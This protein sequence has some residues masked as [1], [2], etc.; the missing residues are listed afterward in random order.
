MRVI[1][2]DWSGDAVYAARKIWLAEA[3][4]GRLLRLEDG[5][6][7]SELA[8]HLVELARDEPEMVVGLDFAFSAP[9]WFLDEHGL[10]SAPDL[11]RLAEHEG[12][13][14]L[15][16]CAPPF[17]GRK[18]TRALEAS[19]Q[20]RRTEAQLASAGARP[21][22]IFQ[23]AGSGA[24]GTGSIR[25]MAVLSR[26]SREGFSVWP[27]AP[28]GWPRI[29]EIYPRLLTGAIKKRRREE[30]E[31]YLRSNYPDLGDEWRELAATSEDSFDA[32]IS[33][34]AMS[35]RADELAS[36]DW[37]GD[38]QL[39]REGAIWG[40][41]ATPPPT[42]AKPPS[43]KRIAEESTPV[44]GSVSVRYTARIGDIPEPERPR[45]RLRRYGP[46]ALS[47]GELL[48]IVLG[49]GGRGLSALDLGNQV[50]ARL[51]GLG[52]IQKATFDELQDVFAVGPAKAAQIKAA[53][54]LGKRLVVERPAESKLKM[55]SPLDVA[56][57][58]M[59]DMGTLEQEELRVL[60]VNARNELDD[61]RMVYRGNVTS[62][63]VRPAEVLR[64]AVRTNM[65]A[66]VLVHNH[67]S[68][69]PS[70]SSADIEVTK[71]ILE[72]GRILGISV[73]DHIVIGG[74]RFVSMQEQKLG[75][76]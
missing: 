44:P 58:L 75:F 26:L 68:G 57:L 48:A 6:S 7:P 16:E 22:S 59:G 65:P 21:K 36:L 71:E 9:A 39:R 46:G 27:F 47:S 42:A 30:R 52:G 10:A 54:E 67:P 53:L 1:A 56:M 66:V 20:F 73:L 13:R 74:G 63:Q 69:D 28:P 5:R 64:D 29:I 31:E 33:A 72:A 18:G 35:C 24:V 70:P 37:S 8:Q 17:W 38:E 55:H 2:V 12:E 41:S 60:L 61:S 25:G 23:I 45:E 50:L 14:W 49:S 40:Y 15:R 3:R 51:K 11:W 76:Q 32:A 62:A 4:Q 43:G 19:R 34:L